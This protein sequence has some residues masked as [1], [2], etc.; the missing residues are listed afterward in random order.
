MG[1]SSNRWRGLI[2]ACLA[3]ALVLAGC[4]STPGG[5]GDTGGDGGNP[6]NGDPVPPPAVP[7]DLERSLVP[8][9][10]D[11]TLAAEELGV[12]AAVPEV[13]GLPALT[14]AVGIV[15]AKLLRNAAA[16]GLPSNL[17]WQLT[18]SGPGVIGV[19]LSNDSGDRKEY[20]S[21]W[22]D[23]ATGKAYSSQALI[24]PDK[25]D[26][27]KN[28]VVRALAE[29]RL[30]SISMAQS[31]GE[32]AAPYGRAPV[33]SFSP[34]GDLVVRVGGDLAPEG[35][36]GSIP[37]AE[38]QPL[39]S[40]LGVAAQRGASDPQPFSGQPPADQTGPGAQQLP[41]DAPTPTADPNRETRPSIK[42]GPDCDKLNCVAVTFDDGPGPRT[43]DVRDA[44]IDAGM[45]TTFFELGQQVDKHPEVTAMLVASGMEVGTHSWSHPVLPKLS[46]AKLDK[47]L[48][49]TLTAI[50]DATGGYNSPVMRP[51]YGSGSSDLREA[52]G[53]RGEAIILWSVDTNDWQTKSTDA[54]VQQVGRAHPGS[55]VLMH[56]IHDFTV[57]AVPI[58]LEQAKEND[59]T[60]VTVSELLGETEPGVVYCSQRSIG[61]DCRSW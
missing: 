51:P 1:K 5:G 37:A 8:D 56:D 43:R 29:A 50:R 45:A 6:G 53:A 38:V 58:M 49:D 60:F 57:D 2:G 20:A 14:S 17:T 32:P 39:L 7:A 44:F 33:M 9:V 27:F 13:P 31:L 4:G 34:Q 11:A 48:D 35:A 61:D 41:A 59:V 22:F 47:E 52:V 12:T 54:T 46:D 42:P 18:S 19:L 30:D 40:S 23:A 15:R 10:R 36:Q 16:A 55:I 21:V 3:L 26:E 24:G 28:L 25:W